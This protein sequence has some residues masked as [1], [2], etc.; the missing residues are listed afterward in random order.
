MRIILACVALLVSATAA[1]IAQPAPPAKAALSHTVLFDRGTFGANC[2]RI[3]ALVRTKSGALLAFAEKRISGAAWCHDVG[4]I[5]LVMRRSTDNGRTWGPQIVVLEGTDTDPSAPATRGNPAPIVDQATGNIL[6]LSTFNPADSDAI[7]TP[8]FQ[9]S[10]DEGLTWSAPRSLATAIDHPAWEWYATGPGHGIQLQTGPNAGRI[11]VGT[12]FQRGDGRN[13]A[14]LVYTDDGGNTWHIGAQDVRPDNTIIPQE[15]S[16][17]ER[18]DGT[19]YAAARDDSQADSG[20]NRAYATSSDGGLTFD[21]PFANVPGLIADS[22]QGSTLVVRSTAK[23]HK[24]N[25]VLFTAPSHPTLRR[26]MV[27]RS[28]YD[29]GKTWQGVAD[30]ADVT[31]DLYSGYSDM[32]MLANGEIG[33]LYEG[34]AA[35][36]RDQVRFSYFTEAALG[37]PD[38]PSGP[39]TPDLS[40]LDN[41]AYLRNGPTYVAGRFD[42]A[43]DLDGFDDHVQLP[44]AESLAFGDGDFT[45]MTWFRYGATQTDQAILWSYQVGSGLSQFWLRA[46]PGANR[47]RGYLQTAHGSAQVVS[48]QDYANNAWHHVA[49]QRSGSTL[50]LFVDGAQVA[51]VTAPAGTVSPIR[52]FK[53]VAGQRLDGTQRLDGQLDELRMYNRAL[54]LTEVRDAWLDNRADISG[55]VLRLPFTPQGP[56]TPDSSGAGNHGLVRGGATLGSGRYGQSLTLDGADDWVAVP[57]SH[58]L[59]LGSAD[60]TIAAWIRYGA[61]STRQTILWG[62]QVGA[63]AGAQIWL[64]A[65]PA[66]NS[67]RAWVE[68]D[69]GSAWLGTAGA[70][71]DQQWHFVVLQR[72]EG[73]LRLSVDGGTPVTAAAPAGSVTAGHGGGVYGYSLGQKLD[74]ADRLRGSLDEVRVWSRALSA[75]E[76]QQVMQSNAAPAGAVL[77]LGL[78]SV[79]SSTLG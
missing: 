52:P 18:N 19:I 72:A 2:Y 55:S 62:Y 66:D 37:L 21:A 68:T 14:Q 70:Y 78:D 26:D 44:F 53:M 29:E 57:Y 47:L 38:G 6:L 34:G 77:R 73:Q 75:E 69:S 28:S 71:N 51:S 45:A 3:P 13:G 42:Q 40:G 15:L 1:A 23:G 48:A 27:I 30:S 63:S 60:F 50:K 36:A 4:H 54:T 17:F 10:T 79:L 16:L 11:V 65:Q 59:N 74:G 31:S 43:L 41:D 56:S 22:V 5:D 20:I 7:R 25:R 8:Y 32:A 12:N 61:S 39:K 33:L 46:E 24:Y 64:R 49:I 58:S 67:I 76:L 9:M 35:D